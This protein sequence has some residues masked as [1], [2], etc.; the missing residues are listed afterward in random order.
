M[1]NEVIER[2][3]VANKTLGELGLYM[4]WVLEMSILLRVKM[5]LE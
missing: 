5:L 4:V 1:Q 2:I 3:K